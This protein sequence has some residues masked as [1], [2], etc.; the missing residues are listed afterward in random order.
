MLSPYPAGA[1]Q[2][3]VFT[4]IKAGKPWS[5]APGHTI[6]VET[7]ASP[8]TASQNL[9]VRLNKVAWWLD[10]Q[11]SQQLSQLSSMGPCDPLTALPKDSIIAAASSHE[12]SAAQELD[13]KDAAAG[14]VKPSA[15]QGSGSILLNQPSS[16]SNQQPKGV[17]NPSKGN[18]QPSKGSRQL[19]KSISQPLQGTASSTGQLLQALAAVLG[20]KA[21]DTAVSDSPAASPQ[22]PQGASDA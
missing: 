21:I 22:P 3:A 12:S 2:D 8:T 14:W 17:S 18:S 10:L 13:C 16:D 4:G 20:Y 11:A 19:A 6:S 15:V 5:M 1:H 7:T 9:R